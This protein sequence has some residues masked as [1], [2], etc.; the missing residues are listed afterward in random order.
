MAEFPSKSEN[1]EDIMASVLSASGDI[2]ITHDDG[3]DQI[4]VDVSTL[5]DEE[6]EDIVANLISGGNAATVSYD[7]SGDTLT[8]VVDEG[9][10]SHGN[11]SGIAPDSHH[12]KTSSASELSDVSPDSDSS[13]HHSKTPV[14]WEEI[15]TVSNGNTGTALSLTADTSNVSYDVYRLSIRSQNHSGS[16]GGIYLKINGVESS[17]EYKHYKINGST[18][19]DS[20]GFTIGYERY[21]SGDAWAVGSAFVYTANP[22][23]SYTMCVNKCMSPDKSYDEVMSRGYT[24]TEHTSIDSLTVGPNGSEGTGELVVEGR[25]R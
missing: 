17:N 19:S 1:I 18:S 4:V 16:G 11:L 13:A 12:S 6:V 15:T 3:N 25:N 9:S 14:G 5:S 24:L 21:G 20:L 22:G 23:D 10:I 7:D 2:S 8:V